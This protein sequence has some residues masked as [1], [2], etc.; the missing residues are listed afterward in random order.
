M[1][2]INKDVWYLT[3]G[4]PVFPISRTARR[5]IIIVSENDNVF[6][7]INYY[8]MYIRNKVRIVLNL[9]RV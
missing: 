6:S 7:E 5:K 8:I 4:N 9:F 2:P 3:K 1:C